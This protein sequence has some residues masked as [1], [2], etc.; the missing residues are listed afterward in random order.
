M[1]SRR[2]YRDVDPAAVVARFRRGHGRGRPLAALVDAAH[3]VLARLACHSAVRLGQDLRPEQARALLRSMDE[4]DFSGNCP[5]GR[6]A[7]V[8]LGRGDLERWFKR[9]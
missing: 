4:A 8:R 3:D 7:Y 5:H 1:R 6:P 2:R 9:A